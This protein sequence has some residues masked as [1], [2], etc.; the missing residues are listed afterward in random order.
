MNETQYVSYAEWVALIAAIQKKGITCQEFERIRTV[1]PQ[2]AG[3]AYTPVIYKE[4]GKLEEYLLDDSFL[5]FQR[6][7]SNSLEERDIELA[8]SAIRSLKKN[9]KA[10]LFFNQI[11]EYAESIKSGMTLEVQKNM[12]AFRQEY[13][14]Y[15]RRLEYSD[16]S[17]FV[18]DL[19]YRCRKK[20]SVC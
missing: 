11:P 19:I 3:E 17:G 5:Q 6:T 10:C 15:L 13:L 14:K 2:A 7:V 9:L 8:E 4:L 12:E 18:Q 20:M 1:Y 16:N